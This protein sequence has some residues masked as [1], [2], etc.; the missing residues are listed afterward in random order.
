MIHNYSGK[1]LWDARTGCCF[2]VKERGHFKVLDT[3]PNWIHFVC[4]KTG[5]RFNASYEYLKQ[6]DAEYCSSPID[7]VP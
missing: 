5:E 3:F 2:I 1:V 6:L 7:I 4:V